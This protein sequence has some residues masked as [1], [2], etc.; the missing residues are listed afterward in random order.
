M[1]TNASGARQPAGTESQQVPP[2]TEGV[3]T[4]GTVAKADCSVICPL[5]TQYSRSSAE[6]TTAEL[7]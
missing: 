5:A 2:H 4:A 7:R 6:E 3:L 1:S